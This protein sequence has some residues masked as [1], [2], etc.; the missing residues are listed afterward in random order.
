MK[1][2]GARREN[3]YETSVASHSCAVF[4]Y[5][6]GKAKYWYADERIATQ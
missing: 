3:Y 1:N 2:L 5:S 4:F 6:A